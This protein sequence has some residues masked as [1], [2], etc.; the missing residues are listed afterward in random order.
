MLVESYLSKAKE[1]MKIAEIAFNEKCYNACVNRAYYAMFQA[2]VAAL[3]SVGITSPSNVIKHEWVQANFVREFIHRRKVYPRF[4]NYLLDVQE[5]RNIAD[6][7][8]DSVSPKIASRKFSKAREF[9]DAIT[10]ELE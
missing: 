3:A 6:Y 9:V 5:T 1:N 2:A 8:S 10:K 4:R 7:E